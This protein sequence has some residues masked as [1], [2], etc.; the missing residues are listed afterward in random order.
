M[1]SILMVSGTYNYEI[2]PW[3][4][5][6][7]IIIFWSHIL[8][9]YWVSNLYFEVIEEEQSSFHLSPYDIFWKSVIIHFPGKILKSEKWFNKFLLIHKI[10]ENTLKINFLKPFYFL[11]C[12]YK[13]KTEIFFFQTKL[14]RSEL[15]AKLSTSTMRSN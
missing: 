6:K 15:D 7:I 11:I 2:L 3:D 14:T 1:L 8:Q 4:N 12:F 10:L 5:C 9:S 13:F